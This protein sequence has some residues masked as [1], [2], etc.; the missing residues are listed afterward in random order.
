V[1][2]V[3]VHQKYVPHAFYGA[4]K[5][6]GRGEAVLKLL[7]LLIGWMRKDLVDKPNLLQEGKTGGLGTQMLLLLADG[8]VG[9]R[10]QGHIFRWSI[11]SMNRRIGAWNWLGKIGPNY[12]GYFSVTIVSVPGG[13]L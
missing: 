5:L 3:A 11:Q 10:L 13:E 9:I 2:N 8:K 7:R 4:T 6:P 1:A 12:L